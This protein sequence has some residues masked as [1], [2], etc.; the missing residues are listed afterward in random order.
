MILKGYAWWGD[1]ILLQFTNSPVILVMSK[2]EFVP[3]SF[4][5]IFNGILS[6]FEFY[7]PKVVF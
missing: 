5:E 4:K 3:G 7:E 6:T 1:V 2:T